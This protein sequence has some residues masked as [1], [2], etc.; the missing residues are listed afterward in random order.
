MKFEI[1]P[2]KHR[3]NNV[4]FLCAFSVFYM[5]NIFRFYPHMAALCSD[6]TLIISEGAARFL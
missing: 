4:D 3:E 6:K 2:P 1:K 5:A